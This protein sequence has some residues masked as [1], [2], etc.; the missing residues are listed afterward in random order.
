MRSGEKSSKLYEYCRGFKTSIKILNLYKSLRETTNIKA[1]E[2]LDPLPRELPVFRKP[3][4]K[5][6]TTQLEIL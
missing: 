4:S 3:V 1:L 6:L 5:L 2:I